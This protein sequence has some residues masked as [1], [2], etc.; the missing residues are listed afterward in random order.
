MIVDDYKR[1]SR[2]MPMSNPCLYCTKNCVAK[3]DY[4]CDMFRVMFL[5]A[6]DE[7]TAFL[8]EKMGLKKEYGHGEK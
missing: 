2:P 1:P 8:R 4:K 3:E 7:T 5:Q 6:W